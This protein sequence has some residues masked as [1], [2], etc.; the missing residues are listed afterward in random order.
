MLPDRVNTSRVRHSTVSNAER[1][2]GARSISTSV[3]TPDRYLIGILSK[4]AGSGR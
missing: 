1:H 2:V 4:S 3:N